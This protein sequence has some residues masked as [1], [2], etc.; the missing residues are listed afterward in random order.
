MSSAV[1]WDGAVYRADEAPAGLRDRAFLL[2]DGLYETVL[3]AG[4][5]PV[6]LQ[7]HLD[8]LLQSATAL[9]FDPP[10]GGVETVEQAVAATLEHAVGDRVAVRI[11]LTRGPGPRG[12][13]LPP[14]QRPTLLVQAEAFDPAARRT[15]VATVVDAPRIDPLDPI[16]PHKT[17]S[18]MRWVEARR[19]ARS[20]GADFALVKT[21]AG[22]VAEADF[23]NLF[24]VVADAVVTP[25]LSRGVLPGITRAWAIEAL[26]SSAT[27]VV[28]RSLE[29]TD[30][31]EASEVFVTSSLVG[32]RSMR[33]LNGRE[34]GA[35]TPV[36]DTLARAFDRLVAHG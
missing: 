10:A 12:V 4:G 18:A 9:G 29:T 7:A 34:L 33:E 22:D 26:G 19:R 15:D 32:V 27:A 24:A 20:A 11:T 3:V 14:E 5:R 1:W 35:Q 28:E 17:I 8:R 21:T 36:A 13:G 2:G 25:P 16:A 31:L 6:L 23:A 30:L